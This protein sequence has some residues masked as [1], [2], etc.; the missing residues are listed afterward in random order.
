[1]ELETRLAAL[2]ERLARLEGGA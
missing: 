1:A 2:E